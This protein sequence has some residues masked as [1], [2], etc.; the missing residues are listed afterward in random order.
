VR[1]SLISAELK[2]VEQAMIIVPH[3]YREGVRGNIVYQVRYPDDAGER[4]YKRWKQRFIYNVAVNMNY[5]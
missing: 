3:E 5:L 1:L 2:A 4:T